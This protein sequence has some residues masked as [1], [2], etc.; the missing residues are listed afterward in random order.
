M[1]KVTVHHAGPGNG[2]PFK[3]FQWMKRATKWADAV[4]P[5]GLEAMKRE[6][7]VGRAIPGEPYAPGQMRM[8]TR[9][10]RKSAAGSVSLHYGTGVKYARWVVGGA[11]PHSIYPVAAQA[12]RFYGGHGQ[13]FLYRKRVNHPGNRPNPYPTRAIKSVQREMERKLDEIMREA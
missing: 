11:R 9:Y 8:K 13:L 3:D 4:G 12:L 6:T 5:P 7:P 10:E 1:I 2:N